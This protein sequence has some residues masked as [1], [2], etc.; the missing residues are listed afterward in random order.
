MSSEEEDYLKSVS[1]SEQD[2]D[3]DDSDSQGSDEGSDSGS[4]D[5]NNDDGFSGGFTS[6]DDDGP[7]VKRVVKTQKQKIFEK[8]REII[9]AIKLK[10][11]YRDFNQMFDKFQELNKEIATNKIFFD[12]EGIPKMYIYYIWMMEKVC[13]NLPA[14]E[15]KNLNKTNL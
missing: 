5:G 2:D 12:K 8:L 4:D 14:S 3:Y 7:A 6:D 13:K 9:N 11:E 10:I 1:G 15:K